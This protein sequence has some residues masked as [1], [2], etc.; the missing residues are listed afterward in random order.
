MLAV[1]VRIDTAGALCLGAVPWHSDRLQML[2]SV[3]LLQ[4]PSC[5]LPCIGLQVHHA[6]ASCPDPPASCGW[7]Q[8]KT[9]GPNPQ[10]RGTGCRWHA[11][12]VLSQCRGESNRRGQHAHLLR[13]AL[14]RHTNPTA[15]LP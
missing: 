2:R 10:V 7:K 5:I 1:A 11:V 13:C 8:F 15:H 9:G 6:A 12:S 3:L 4:T 14:P